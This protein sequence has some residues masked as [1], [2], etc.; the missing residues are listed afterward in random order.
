MQCRVN[1]MLRS[2]HGEQSVRSRRHCIHH[3]LI[4]VGVSMTG[5]WH[6]ES[7]KGFVIEQWHLATTMCSSPSVICEGTAH[8]RNVCFQALNLTLIISYTTAKRQ[9]KWWTYFIN[10]PENWMDGSSIAS[11][12]HAKRIFIH[13][14]TNKFIEPVMIAICRSI[15]TRR[16]GSVLEWLTTRLLDFF[17]CFKLTVEWQWSRRRLLQGS[18]S[19]CGFS[20]A[21]VIVVSDNV[22]LTPYKPRTSCY[23]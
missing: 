23:C 5:M 2:I 11:F 1:R 21:C 9:F 22:F 16:T 20:V 8:T 7:Y 18:Y 12:C 4:C 15:F 19:F 6:G 3:T 10:V 14:Q 17:S 13:G